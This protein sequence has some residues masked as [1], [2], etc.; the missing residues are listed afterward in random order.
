MNLCKVMLAQAKFMKSTWSTACCGGAGR[1]RFQGAKKRPV[2]GG[3][4]NALVAN[5]VKAVLTT[6]TL[7]LAKASSDSVSGDEQ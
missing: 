4:L 2:E 5:L 6:N 3:E 1:I 7:K